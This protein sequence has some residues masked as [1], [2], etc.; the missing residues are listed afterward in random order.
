MS[1]SELFVVEAPEELMVLGS[2]DESLYVSTAT[3][4]W[5]VDT[6]DQQYNLELTADEFTLEIGDQSEEL[7]TQ[8]A[9]ELLVVNVGPQ[10]ASGAGADANLGTFEAAENIPSSSAVHVTTTGMAYKADRTLGRRANGF[11]IS[12]I[13]S[14]DSFVVSRRGVL[15]GLSGKTSGATQ[16]LST[17][18][19]IT[20]TLPTSAGIIQEVGIAEDSSSVYFD[21]AQVFI[22]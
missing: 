7:F 3:E 16:W 21:P 19:M 2:P 8:Q 20:E 22:K 4:M 9:S 10:G 12:G 1:V 15:E 13:N 6:E 11:T 5:Q 14:G 18:G 17:G